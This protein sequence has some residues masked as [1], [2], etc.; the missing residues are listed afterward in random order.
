MARCGTCAPPPARDVAE[1][2][3][4]GLVLRAP[5][6]AEAY[7]AALI[8]D[9]DDGDLSNGTPHQ[10]AIDRAFAAHG[11]QPA[12]AALDAGTPT[13]DGHAITIAVART[14]TVDPACPPIEV[15]SIAVAWESAGQR[16]GTL[17]LA[18]TGD[19]WSAP[20]PDVPAGAIVRYTVAITR[21]DGTTTVRPD[22]PADPQYEA[23]A[24]DAT[25]LWCASMDRDPGLT[26]HGFS[27]GPLGTDPDASENPHAAFTGTN[28]VGNTRA[29]FYG[30]DVRATAAAP[31][32]DARG[33]S[34]VHL[35]FARW[36]TVQDFAFDQA[37]VEVNGATAWRNADNAHGTGDHIDREW[38]F[39]D[40]DV[41]DAAAAGPL[42]VRWTLAS[43]DDGI[44]YG[45]WN[46]DDVCVVAIDAP[47]EVRAG[48]GCSG[49]PGAGML[50]GV[51]VMIVLRRR[52]R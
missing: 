24:G 50:A 41:S 13:S 28:V 52:R 47:S 48:G 40:L 20:L 33:H 29:S 43:N 18:A 19:T 44:A 49:A 14:G 26:L 32:I 36:L 35:Q 1:T 31:P 46:L 51:P 39:V 37:T 2:V 8:E 9:D 45:G 25:S 5:N 10:C 34:S 11:L 38:R 12:Y 4:H 3:F 15:A 22:N 27:Y 17:D 23:L 7:G 42:D 16:S 30:S 6:I 21:A